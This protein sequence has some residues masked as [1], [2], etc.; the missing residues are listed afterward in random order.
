M[1]CT[2]C[3]A[4]P[5]EFERVSRPFSEHLSQVTV[6][7]LEQG[8]CPGCGEVMTSYP[9]WSQL[10]ALVVAAL[11]AKPSRLT[12]G[13]IRFLRL[14][15]GLRA[16]ELAETLGVT[17][18]QVSRWEKGAVTISTLADRLLRM[19]AAS[20]TGLPAPKLANIDTSHSA[21]LEMRIKRTSRGWKA[22]HSD[23]Q[24]A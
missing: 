9:R 20:R 17:P 16:Q 7:G 23:A 5:V 22:V 21:P 18:S 11:L 14:K 2:T 1:K 8:M 15:T 4:E 10:S 3:G 24:A 13:E 6:D 12:P 19:V